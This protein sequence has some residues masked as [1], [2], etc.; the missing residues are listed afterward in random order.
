MQLLSE[1]LWALTSLWLDNGLSSSASV[2]QFDGSYVAVDQTV[3]TD[4]QFGYTGTDP[5][6]RTTGSSPRN[7]EE[8]FPRIEQSFLSDGVSPRRS[9]TNNYMI[10]ESGRDRP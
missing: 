4:S 9:S 1:K 8:A 7:G 6:V 10:V 5:A 3:D 2:V